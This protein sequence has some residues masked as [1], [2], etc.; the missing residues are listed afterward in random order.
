MEVIEVNVLDGFRD[1]FGLVVICPLIFPDY[2]LIIV[3]NKIEIINSMGVFA[4]LLWEE[5]KTSKIKPAQRLFLIR[6]VQLLVLINDVLLLLL[7][8]FHLKIIYQFF[9][10]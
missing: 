7:R 1:E 10:K 3:R 6:K 8:K 9:Y 2:W 5:A 4:D